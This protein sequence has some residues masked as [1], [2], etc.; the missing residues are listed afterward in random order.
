MIGGVVVDLDCSTV[1]VKSEC[2][3]SSDRIAD[4]RQHN[5]D[6]QRSSKA[7]EMTLRMFTT[8]VR[9]EGKLCCWRRS[10]RLSILFSIRTNPMERINHKSSNA[11]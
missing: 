1:K 3:P 4:E 11:S 6:L 2:E 9:R 7:L 10:D 8:T 5:N